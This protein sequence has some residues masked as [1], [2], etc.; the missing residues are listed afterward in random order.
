MQSEIQQQQ[1]G[2]VLLLLRVWSLHAE[3]T[4]RCTDC[5]LRYLRE[6]AVTALQRPLLGIF[7]FFFFSPSGEQ[8]MGIS[9]VAS[10]L[11]R[12]RRTKIL[13]NKTRGS[14]LSNYSS[15]NSQFMTVR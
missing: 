8:S 14:I 7:F 12:G 11:S 15:Y 3:I 1:C 13:A 10:Q 6:G 4:P 2:V 5:Q 9:L